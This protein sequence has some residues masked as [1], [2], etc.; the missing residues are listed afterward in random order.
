M[1]DIGRIEKCRKAG[2]G[3]IGRCPACAEGGADRSGNHLRVWPDGRFA[4]VVNSGKEGAQ[5]RRRI[6]ALVGKKDGKDAARLWSAPS[7]VFLGG[8]HVKPIVIQP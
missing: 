8:K 1:I 2:D 5:H 3:W 7:K 6:F 4:C